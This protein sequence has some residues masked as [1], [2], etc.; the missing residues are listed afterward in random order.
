MNERIV[1][2]SRRSKLSKRKQCRMLSLNRSS[3]YYRPLGIKPENLKLM[4]LKDEHA[5][6]EPAEGIMSMQFM[7]KEKGYHVNY[8]R[9]RIAL[10]E[11]GTSTYLPTKALEQAR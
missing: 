9:V 7:L 3:P 4:K 8:K 5:L 2:V 1:L 11:D 6:K 10:K